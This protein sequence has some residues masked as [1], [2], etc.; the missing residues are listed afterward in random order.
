MKPFEMA[1]SRRRAGDVQMQRR[2][3]MAGQIDV[4]GL[5]Q[6]GNLQK[7]GDAAAA[8]HVGLLHVDGIR[9]EHLANIIDVV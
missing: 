5:A 1:Q 8:G 2:R 9:F 7:G 3:A 6:R 4:K